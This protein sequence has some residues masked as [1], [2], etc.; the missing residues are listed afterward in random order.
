MLKRGNP[1]TLFCMLCLTIFLLAGCGGAKG[2]SEGGEEGSAARKQETAQQ[3]TDTLDG[4]GGQDR[5]PQAEDGGKEQGTAAQEAEGVGTD[6]AAADGGTGTQRELTQAELEEAERFVNE[7]N[8]FLLSEYAAPEDID[9]NEV[10][11][12]GL[13]SSGIPDEEK[14]AYL[15]A[16]GEEE[17]Y[18]DLVRVNAAEADEY[19]LERTG[20]GLEDFHK[21]LLFLYLPAYDAYYAQ[22]GD[23]NACGFRCLDGVEQDGRYLV[24]FVGD[25]YTSIRCECTVTLVPY[26]NGFRFAANRFTWDRFGIYREDRGQ[27]SLEALRL[28]VREY[29]EQSGRTGDGY[30]EA[31]FDTGRRAYTYEELQTLQW[32]EVLLSVYRN[33]IYARHGY[34]FREEL[35]NRFFESYSWYDGSVDADAFDPACFNEYERGNL[36]LALSAAGG[37][38]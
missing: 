10:F 20:L 8:R 24:R 2:G 27:I 13:D 7:N 36:D 34:R 1:P 15:K 12:N 3:E 14:E 18:T 33:E 5:L 22:V 17:L 35:W 4:A 21:G 16:S 28:L 23:S 30:D 9:L 37:K 26:K 6:F 32:D 19:L 25:L 38:N 29:R 31:I 11:Y